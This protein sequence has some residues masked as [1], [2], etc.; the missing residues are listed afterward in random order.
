MKRKTATKKSKVCKAFRLRPECASML[1]QIAKRE[2]ISQ[3]RAIEAALA[4]Y[5]K[6]ISL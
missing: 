2:S 1:E 6:A 4:R 3:V 5:G